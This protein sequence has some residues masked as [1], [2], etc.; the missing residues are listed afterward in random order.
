MSVTATKNQRSSYLYISVLIASA[1]LSLWFNSRQSVINPDAICYLLSAEE[2]GQSGLQSAMHLCP[3]AM[4]PFYSVLIHTIVQFT[5]LSFLHA[6][7]LID[8][9]FTALSVITFV[10]IIKELGGTQRVLWLAAIVILLA[11]QF[12]LLRPEII[13]DHGF[14]AFYLVSILSLLRFFKQPHWQHAIVWSASLFAATLFRMEGAIFLLTLPVLSFFQGDQPWSSRFI[15]FF[16]LNCIMIMVGVMIMGWI[17]VHPLHVSDQ[18]GRIPEVM[19]QLQHAFTI[20]T[21]RYQTTKAAISTHLLSHVSVR[22]AN[23]VVILLLSSWYLV[24]L[25]TNLS[26]IYTFLVIY[27]WVSVSTHFSRSARSVLWGYG[28]INFIVTFGFFAGYQ[29]LAKRYLI[30]FSFILMLFVPFALEK[31]ITSRKRY[32]WRW[33]VALFILISAA[34]GLFH[35]GHSKNHI[36]QAGDWLAEHISL[37]AK[38]YTNDYQIMYY[39]KHFGKNIFQKHREYQ[40]ANV[41][42]DGHWKQYDYLALLTSKDETNKLSAMMQEIHLL[43]KEIFVN[44]RGDQIYIYQ[45]PH[46]E[47]KL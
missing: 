41:I 45:I 5:H 6:A 12:N 47:N 31:I 7:Y 33:P 23:L 13:R 16:Q 1:L 38:L 34:G 8:G 30:A 32:V 29:F 28:L 22:D 3:Q 27:A 2:I 19:N 26:A 40:D 18:L 4:W 11:H 9:M 15:C 46:Q 20:I 36:R 44:N 37:D 10:V 21:E 39:S 43:P 24:S 35:F 25:M 42:A 14:W 17:M